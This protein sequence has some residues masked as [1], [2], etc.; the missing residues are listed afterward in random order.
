M[1]IRT[2]A[3]IIENEVAFTIDLDD[4]LNLDIMNRVI[5]ALLSNPQ[6]IESDNPEI[7]FGWKWDGTNFYLP[8]KGV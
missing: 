7:R 2:F 6:F 1:A 3:V 5:P 8:E 4:S